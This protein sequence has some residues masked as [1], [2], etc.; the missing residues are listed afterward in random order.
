MR[1][2]CGSRNRVAQPRGKVEDVLNFENGD[3]HN[4]KVESAVNFADGSQLSRHEGAEMGTL[5]R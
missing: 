4:P 3:D 1:S 5:G 2:P